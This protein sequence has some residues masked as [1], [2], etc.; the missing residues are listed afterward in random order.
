MLTPLICLYK[1]GNYRNQM[2]KEYKRDESNLKRVIRNCSK[3]T[4]DTRR[5]RLIIYYR[6]RKLGNLIIKNNPNKPK[7]DFNVGYKHECSER[8][9]KETNT[10]NIGMKTV[11]IK[12]WFKQHASIKKHYA[13]THNRNIT[14]SEIISNVSVLTREREKRDLLIL[15]ALL[16]KDHN[17]F[18]NRQ[19]EDFIRVLKVF[20]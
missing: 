7:E 15:E 17:P 20:S 11:T 16:I 4:D 14:G 9:C 10:F 6:N 19:C 5:I 18:I 3:A 8:S 1:Y 13:T 12:E 2:T